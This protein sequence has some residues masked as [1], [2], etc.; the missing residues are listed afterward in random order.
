[1]GVGVLRLVR[2]YAFCL[3]H[4]LLLNL[5]LSELS[6]VLLS[7]SG[8]PRYCA[9]AACIKLNFN[10]SSSAQ[11]HGSVHLQEVVDCN[12]GIA[13][14]SST[15]AGTMNCLRGVLWGLSSVPSA[16]LKASPMGQ[17]AVAGLAAGFC[18]P[19][20]LVAWVWSV[21]SAFGPPGSAII[22]PGEDIP[23]DAEGIT[24]ECHLAK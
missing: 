15:F 2:L 4:C 5:D 6:L 14:A 19:F 13:I 8:P 11:L 20:S 18:D 1:M 21:A 23:L 16:P 9:N 24:L 22:P 10:T 12:T 17:D 3:L 7:V